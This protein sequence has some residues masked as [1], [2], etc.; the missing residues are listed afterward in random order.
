M[1][2]TEPAASLAATPKTR[3]SQSRRWFTW[4]VPVAAA[5]VVLLVVWVNRPGQPAPTDAKSAIDA[6]ARHDEAPAQP[7]TV[8]EQPEQ[9]LKRQE[10]FANKDTARDANAPKLDSLAKERKNIAAPAPAA[11]AAAA[12]NPAKKA[13][14]SQRLAAALVDEFRVAEVRTPDGR[15]R[16]RV[17]GRVVERSTD[18]GTTWSPAPTGLDVQLTGGSAPADAVCW[19]IGQR[20]VVLL[21]TDG[22]TWRRVPFPEATDLSAIQAS[23]ARNATVATADGRTFT[24]TDGGQTWR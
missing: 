9:Q 6:V 3:E 12:A 16:W 11:P 8:R 17:R 5:A 19:L 13:E 1:V 4:V 21:S 7:S 15:V 14:E 23:D 18:A 20:G 22:L 2:R 10:A 24:T